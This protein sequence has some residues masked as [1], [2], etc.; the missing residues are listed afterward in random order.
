MSNL[1]IQKTSLHR[2]RSF[3]IYFVRLDRGSNG[4][5]LRLNLSKNGA[6]G[7]SWGDLTLQ[8]T[9]LGKSESWKTVLTACLISD[10][11]WVLP[12]VKC[13]S[14]PVNVSGSWRFP[15]PALQAPASR[16]LLLPSFCP[17]EVLWPPA[18]CCASQVSGGRGTWISLCL[19]SSTCWTILLSPFPCVCVL[20]EMSFLSLNPCFLHMSW[21]CRV[22]G[23]CCEEWKPGLQQEGVSPASYFCW[24]A[25][26]LSPGGPER[27]CR[28]G[29]FLSQGSRCWSLPLTLSIGGC[30]NSGALLVLNSSSLSHNRRLF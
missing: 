30:N 3:Q 9:N 18:L 29:W 15:C 23:R 27:A 20:K 7:L 4:R 13:R 5:F 17:H 24:T 1:E 10:F 12:N 28:G 14:N 19:L 6:K 2:L 8:P 25:A 21:K 26:F 22:S 16:S 11:V